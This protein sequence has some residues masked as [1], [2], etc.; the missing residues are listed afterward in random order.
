M[1]ISKRIKL[2]HESK[3]L[4][5]RELAGII[6]ISPSFLCRIENGSS[7]SNINCICDIAKAL[8]CTL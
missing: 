2:L 7:T 4:S 6:H 5:Q 8:Q 1:T 3:D